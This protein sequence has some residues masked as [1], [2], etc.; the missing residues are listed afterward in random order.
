[1]IESFV[2]ATDIPREWDDA[3]G[4][5]IYLKRDFLSFMERVN[6]C[7]QRYYMIRGNGDPDTV[8]VT[9]VLGGYNLAMFTRFRLLVE[10]TFVYVPLSVTRPG[11]AFGE[12]LGEALDFI[13]KIK[14][15]KIILNL[16]KYPFPGFARGY[17]CP[18]CILAIAWRAFDEY[19]GS[20]RSGYRHRCLKAIRKSESLRMR[21]LSDGG[22][23]NDQMY[24]LYLQV[25]DHSETKIEK[26]S[27]G[28]FEGRFFRIFVLERD[29]RAHGFVQLLENGDELIFEFVGFDYATNEDYDTYMRMLLEI[30]RY[31]I[32][33]GFKTIDFGQTADETKLRLGSE[34]AYLYAYLHHSNAFVNFLCGL[35]APCLEY[36]PIATR[37]SVFKER[38]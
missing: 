16:G 37:F 15:Y 9:Y 12:R 8:F 6:A 7:R 11:I 36:R 1:M 20:L 3:I 33:H 27:K 23:F 28:F 32:E 22:E 24:S 5:N 2:S 26:L 17:T 30:V 18:K 34:Y 19:L 10:M 29:S 35:L 21:F 38:I 14:G 25:Y 4:D 31:G 13:K